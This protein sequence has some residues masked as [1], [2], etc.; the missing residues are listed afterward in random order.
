MYKIPHMCFQALVYYT[1]GALGGNLIAHM[2]LVSWAANVN[3]GSA[4]WQR[5][6]CLFSLGIQILGRCWCSTELR[7]GV[8]ALQARGKSGWVCNIISFRLVFLGQI[9]WREF[10]LHLQLS[11][12][13]GDAD[14]RYGCTEDQAFGRGGEPRIYQRDAG[15]GPDPV[16]PVFS[17]ERRRTSPGK[18]EPS[19]CFIMITW[20]YSDALTGFGSSGRSA[21]VSYTCTEDVE[22]SRTIRWLSCVK[23]FTAITLWDLI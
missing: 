5:V 6:K 3:K 16:L 9:T 4:H 13:W 22:W 1:F 23:W 17:W 8:N 10:N 20:G 2:I 12:Q 18:M 21:W 7:V 19:G 11:G 14:R 15:G